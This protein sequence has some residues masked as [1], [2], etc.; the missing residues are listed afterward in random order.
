MRP[1]PR[2]CLGPIACLPRRLRHYGPVC[3]L[4]VVGLPLPLRT[5]PDSCMSNAGLDF[6]QLACVILHLTLDIGHEPLHCWCPG[7]TSLARYASIFGVVD[8]SRTTTRKNSAI[9]LSRPA[10]DET[11]HPSPLLTM[12]ESL[13]FSARNAMQLRSCLSNCSTVSSISSKKEGN[14]SASGRKTVSGHWSHVLSRRRVS[15]S[16]NPRF[17]TLDGRP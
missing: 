17:D 16:C 7:E 14:H 10:G 1:S 3:P 8:K 4:A 5:K 15:D 13:Y 11:R 12:H 6:P 9:P 2:W